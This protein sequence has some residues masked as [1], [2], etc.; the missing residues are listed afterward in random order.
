MIAVNLDF[1]VQAALQSV[2]AN[3]VAFADRFPGDTTIG[4]QYFLRPA[5]ND[6]AIGD[7]YGW[8]T[9][10]WSGI[11]WL[12]YELTGKESYRQLGEQ[13]IQNFVRRVEDGVDL[14]THDIGFLYTLAC[15]A[16]WRITG[17]TEPRRA[18]LQAAEH[19]MRRYLKNAG[20]FQAWGM[21]DDP[22]QRGN[23]IIDSLMNMPLLYWATEQTGDPRYAKA[24]HRHAAELRDHM[25]R[26]DNTT[27]HTF[28]WD[29]NTGA[30]LSGRTAQ[31]YA[32]DSCWARGQAWAIYGFTLNYR[33]TQ[34]DSLLATAQ[35]CADYFL[36]HLPE[37]Q[38]AF[39]DLVFSDGSG[40]ERDSS[41]A[42]IA[43]CGLQEMARWLPEGEQ[44]R[45]QTAAETMMA[46]LVTRYA[47]YHNPTSN[48]LLL[49]S[50]YDK[51]KGIGVDE[52]CLWGDYFYMEALVRTL[53]PN[54]QLYW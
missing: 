24:A 36:D 11:L 27:Y 41:A 52:A 29:V 35:R 15:V 12:A 51:P 23:T 10:F 17:D 48:A 49:H 54:W 53:N 14:D 33:Y 31:G 46:S 1:T 39:W 40:E 37:D 3:I 28:Y 25:I 5:H 21:L 44:Q 22:L 9:S 19:L 18:A 43:V 30:P 50:V 4:N 47:A 13:H 20:V 8:T 45:Y 16:P 38:V 2:D 42:A 26:A 6:F 7:N 32:D 34:D